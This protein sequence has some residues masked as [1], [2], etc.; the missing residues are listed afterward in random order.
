MDI[1]TGLGFVGGAIVAATVIP[2]GGSFGMDYCDHAI[3]ISGG[4]FAATLI[5][6][7]RVFDFPRHPA[8][9]QVRLH[10]AAHDATRAR[11]PD[12]AA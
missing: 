6:F 10:D 5:R 9:R 12:R 3:I 8:R 4:S 11:R 7:P 1:A 2:M